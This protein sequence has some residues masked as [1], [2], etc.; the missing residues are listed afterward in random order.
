MTCH[1]KTCAECGND[2][3]VSCILRSPKKQRFCSRKCASISGVI[4]SRAARAASLPQR[5]WALVDRSGTPL[6]CWPF[7]GMLSREGYGRFKISSK[8]TGA[9]RVA[10]RL[11]TSI[12]PV[13]MNV[14]HKCDNPAC[15]N[16]AHLFLGS[17]ADNIKDCIQK[18]RFPKGQFQGNAKLTEKQVK[19][20]RSSD[21]RQAELAQLYGVSQSLISAV[22]T[23]KAWSHV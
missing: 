6:S 19:Q 12:D 22:Q 11:A 23:G 4:A 5:F 9:H 16:P 20:I 17:Q 10:F 18:G 8:N 7:I 21:L 1:N 14:C 15:C 3:V 2:F 13:G